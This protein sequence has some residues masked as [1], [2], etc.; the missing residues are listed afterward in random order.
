MIIPATYR[1]LIKCC[2]FSLQ[3]YDFLNSASS[4]AALV[5]TCQVFVHRGKTEKG[6]SPEYFKIFGKN[7][8]FNEHPVL[9][10]SENKM[11]SY[12]ER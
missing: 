3:F 12:P 8:I 4:T 1:V 9:Q 11:F 7:T 6:Q 2:V 10:V 5:P